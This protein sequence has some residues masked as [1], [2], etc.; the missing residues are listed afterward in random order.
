MISPTKY[1]VRVTLT[2]SIPGVPQQLIESRL[3]CITPSGTTTHRTN[4]LSTSKKPPINPTSQWVSVKRA[5]NRN[6][7]P[8]WNS[9]KFRNCGGTTEV[10]PLSRQVSRFSETFCNGNEHSFIDWYRRC[11]THLITIMVANNTVTVLP[12]VLWLP[13]SA[14]Y[15][16]SSCTTTQI[17]SLHK[18]YCGFMVGTRTYL[19]P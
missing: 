17:P 18:I 4:P 16:I 7:T 19:W 1:L 9:I 15:H 13:W 2:R 8:Y 3:P 14:C 12:A 11:T 6:F 10:W 5:R